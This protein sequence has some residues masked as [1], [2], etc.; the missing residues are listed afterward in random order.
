MFQ[1]DQIYCCSKCGYI[2]FFDEDNSLPSKYK[3]K[4]CSGHCLP[5]GISIPYS[6]KIALVVYDINNP[7]E[8]AKHEKEVKA[9]RDTFYKSIREQY[10]RNNPEFDQSAWDYR[11]RTEGTV[12]EPRPIGIEQVAINVPHCPTCNS[13]NVTRMSGL[14]RAASVAVLGLFSKKINKSF[15]CNSCGYT[16]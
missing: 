10:C 1:S 15:K 11:E 14:E 13:T 6:E 8:S 2:M 16:W 4:F 3:C 5:T 7:I 12:D 9:K